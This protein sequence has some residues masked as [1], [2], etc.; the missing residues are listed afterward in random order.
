VIPVRFSSR[1]QAAHDLDVHRN[2][3][4]K[5]VGEAVSDPGSAF[6][7]HGIIK[8]EQQV[9]ERLRRELARMEARRAAS[10]A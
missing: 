3:L 2:V 1:A 8:Q 10:T 9:I 7:G 4:F 6:L 5:W